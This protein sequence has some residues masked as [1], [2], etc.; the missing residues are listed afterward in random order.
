MSDSSPT[1]RSVT[2]RTRVSWGSRLG[3]AFKGIVIGLVL[4]VVGLVLLF[5]NEGRAVQTARSL[6]EAGS[7]VVSVNAGEVDA[8]REGELIHLV[9]PLDV[10]EPVADPEFEVSAEAAKLVR[11]V[12][13]Y[14]WEEERR[15]E[16]RTQTG[17][18]EERVTTYE[19]RPVWSDREIDSSRFELAAEHRNPPKPY[20]NREI[21]AENARIGAFGVGDQVLR[22]LTADRDLP[23]DRGLAE[24]LADRFERPVSVSDGRLL[25]AQDPGNPQIGDLRISFAAA[26]TSEISVVGR[27]T[28]NRIGPYQTQAGDAIL[29][30]QSGTVPADAMIRAAERENTLMTW[31]LRLVGAAAI[32]FGFVMVF[33]PIAVVGDVIPFVG[34]L[35][36]G[37]I[38]LVAGVATLVLAPLVIALAWLAY[39][40]LIAVLVLVLGLAAAFGLQQLLARRAA[41][42]EAAEP[43]DAQEGAG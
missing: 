37:G 31:G 5:W 17:G 10:P 19:Y 12:E 2:R 40:P 43:K 15:T 4:V 13:M 26:P 29:M 3:D 9:G 18:S 8:A 6:A 32:F 14:Q 34:R 24:G 41:E 36:R 33:R 39:R 22:L 1:P 28:G 35:L 23:V 16:T 27:Q 20:G 7:V 42:A 11:T 30:A 25:V 38:G 21:L